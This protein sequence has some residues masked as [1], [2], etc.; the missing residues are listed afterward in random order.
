[1]APTLRGGSGPIEVSIVSIAFG[2]TLP[3]VLAVGAHRRL[4]VGWR[5]F[6]GGALLFFAFHLLFRVPPLAGLLVALSLRFGSATEALGPIGSMILT[7]VNLGLVAGALTEGFRYAGCRWLMYREEKTWAKGVMYGLGCGTAIL[8]FLLLQPFAFAARLHQ[9]VRAVLL[10]DPPLTAPLGVWRLG[11]TLAVQMGLAVLVLQVFRRGSFQ[12]LGLAIVG[13]AV[14]EAAPPI[15]RSLVQL[16]VAS[17]ELQERLVNAVTVATVGVI[18]LVALWT[19]VMLRDEPPETADRTEERDLA[20][21]P[22]RAE[23]G[24]DP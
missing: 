3:L 13:H 12:W 18:G 5:Y 8:W 10:G 14:W 24:E 17:P 20:T 22:E 19:L 6:I 15:A 21:S 11:W 23:S 4:G 16:S 2:L 7:A 1:M 9:P